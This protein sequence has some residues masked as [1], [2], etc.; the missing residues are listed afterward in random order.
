MNIKHILITGGAGFIGSNLAVA[1]RNFDSGISV[2]VIDNLMRTGSELNIPRLRNAGVTFVHG[3]VRNPEDLEISEID[4]IIECSAEPSVT[5]G[6][7]GSPEYVINTNLV[8]ALNCFELARRHRAAVIFLSTSRVYPIALLNNLVVSEGPT[9]F[10]LAD[11]QEL[12]GVSGNGLTEDFPMHGVRSIYGATKYAAELLL[13]EYLSA[14]N[15]KGIVNRFGVISGPYQMGKVDQGV[16][17]LWMAA[18]VFGKQLTYF[19]FGGNGKQ[20]RDILHINDLITLII[21]EIE[22]LDEISGNVFVAGGGKENAVSLCELTGLCQQ[23]SGKKIKVVSKN[24]VR[25]ADIKVYISDNTKITKTLGWKPHHTVKSILTD[26]HSWMM[27]EYKIL[28]PY[29]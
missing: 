9:R 5:A 19:G 14:Y 26:I 23:I 25:K 8:G 10:E 4:L 21:T 7:D 17:A 11:R 16:G 12:A 24:E 22:H 28:Q 13:Q 27:Q 2:T 6:L 29:F 3:D 18:H 20:V 1:L 15:L